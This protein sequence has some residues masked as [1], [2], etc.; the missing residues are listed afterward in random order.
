MWQPCPKTASLLK[1]SPAGDSIERLF[2]MGIDPAVR[3]GDGHAGQHTT[4]RIL[5]FIEEALIRSR[6]EDR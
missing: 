1:P 3:G 2:S 5:V 4:G 6:I